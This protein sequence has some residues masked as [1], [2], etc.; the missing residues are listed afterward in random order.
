[1]LASASR[2]PGQAERKNRPSIGCDDPAWGIDRSADMLT[3]PLPED[4]D[5]GSAWSVLRA[6]S[7]FTS[8]AVSASNR[9][10]QP[11]PRGVVRCRHGCTERA[12]NR[13]IWEL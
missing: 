13:L 7:R 12:A 4:L 8:R 3:V 5:S 9:P 2:R 11:P 10:D 1:M 6:P